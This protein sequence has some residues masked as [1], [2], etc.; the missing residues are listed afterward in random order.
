M[1]TT[2]KD[3]NYNLLGEITN[4]NEEKE[5]LYNKIRSTEINYL[6][7]AKN[8]QIASDIKKSVLSNDNT[9]KFYNDFNE[10]YNKEF[11][12]NIS[13]GNYFNDKILELNTILE[14][15]KKEL[16]KTKLD[17]KQSEIHQS[18]TKSLLNSEYNKIVIHKIYKHLLFITICVLILINLL[19]ILNKYN[20]IE[21]YL[22]IILSIILILLNII[23]TILVLYSKYPREADDHYRFKFKLDNT[24]MDVHHTDNLPNPTVNID[25]KIDELV[26]DN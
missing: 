23:Y 4:Y 13:I 15:K 11:E 1:T 2:T 22:V 24:N 9:V 8:Q 5:A 6:I 20:F 17:I 14:E 16:D 10:Y 25:D 7:N 26:K 21:S 12:N 3:T 19:I 18:T